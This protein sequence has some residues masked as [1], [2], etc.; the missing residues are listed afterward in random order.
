MLTLVSCS[1]AH[2]DTSGPGTSLG[3]ALCIYRVDL[4]EVILW[5]PGHGLHGESTDG[6]EIGGYVKAVH[7]DG[8]WWSPEKEQ[9]RISE[10]RAQPETRL[11]KT[12][13]ILFLP[14]VQ[15]QAAR[16]QVLTPPFFYL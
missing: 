2:R 13:A 16:T 9:D 10:T 3:R 8:S 12:G 6:L 1:K 14:A 11:D 4:S 7:P 15:S 5:H